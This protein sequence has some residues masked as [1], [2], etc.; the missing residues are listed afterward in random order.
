MQFT[1]C[2]GS[3]QISTCNWL[4]DFNELQ[5]RYVN[6][7]ANKLERADFFVTKSHLEYKY[8][9]I[10]KLS[11]FPCLIMGW[12]SYI[13]MRSCYCPKRVNNS[14]D[15]W[16][17]LPLFCVC[18]W[19]HGTVA[20]MMFVCVWVH[21]TVAMMMFVCVWVHGTVAM[22]MFVFLAHFTACLNSC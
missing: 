12:F 13:L 5:Y 10:V 1:N 20:M 2:C 15:T 11:N 8:N 7:E 19:V 6:T 14:H 18:V 16:N 9:Q 21:G 4:Y 17:S 3:K 22:T